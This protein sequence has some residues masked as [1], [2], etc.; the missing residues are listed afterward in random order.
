[1]L[2]FA[3]VFAS[4]AQVFSS[5]FTEASYDDPAAEALLNDHADWLSEGGW[6]AAAGTDRIL[7]NN[8]NWRKVI[9]NTPLTASSG[10]FVS[11]KLSVIF[12]RDTQAF[13]G[14]GDMAF[15]GFKLNNDLSSFAEREGVKVA[16]NGSN[17]E[18]QSQSDNGQGGQRPANGSGQFPSAISVAANVDVAYEVIIEIGVGA[19]AA[20][21]TLSARVDGGTIG[22]VTG[23]D[24]ELYAGITGS[25]I[26]FWTWGYQWNGTGI[27]AIF[28]DS[29]IVN[30]TGT[31][32]ST[33]KNN[34]FEFAMYPNPV[35][36]ELKIN[37]KE[38]IQ[39]L[40]IFDLLGREVLAKTNV[41]D[42]V[43]VSSLR[44]AM[45]VIKLT[46]ANG[47]STKRFIKK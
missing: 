25:G 23:I 21:S 14:G 5:D 29:L 8:A 1:M 22:S 15:F 2:A 46:S 37:T 19:D 47:V 6:Q 43:N 28:F 30:N 32:L 7:L 17:L 26:Y 10:D 39:K 9:L 16:L 13:A 36:N 35:E 34:A 45:Y 20:T 31:A 12:G 44:K 3:V 38:S 24:P 4:N 11:A 27:N 41:F 40:Q 42:A 18:F 33:N